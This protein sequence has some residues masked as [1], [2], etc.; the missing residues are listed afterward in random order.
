MWRDRVLANLPKGLAIVSVVALAA[1][2]ILYAPIATG[3]SQGTGMEIRTTLIFGVLVVSAASMSLIAARGHDF[4]RAVASLSNG[5][6]LVWIFSFVGPPVVIA[7]LMGI[8]AAVTVKPRRLVLLFLPI[9]GAVLGA[10]MLRLTEPPG[11]RLF[12]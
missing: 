5:F 8:A 1:A 7:A 4:V 11:E 3:P 10:L 9:C 2:A 6:N 12:G